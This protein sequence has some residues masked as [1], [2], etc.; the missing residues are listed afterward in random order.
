MKYWEKFSNK[1]SYVTKTDIS[2]FTIDCVVESNG[3][4]GVVRKISLSHL[5]VYVPE[6]KTSEMWYYIVRPIQ[7]V[8]NSRKL[9]LKERITGVLFYDKQ[10][11]ITHK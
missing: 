11:E 10:I 3:E 7:M 1:I 8:R 2:D 6:K 5:V 4:I 9:T